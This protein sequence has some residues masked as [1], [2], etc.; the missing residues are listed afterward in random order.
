MWS[1][2]RPAQLATRASSRSSAARAA[3]R[4]RRLRGARVD[5]ELAPGLG[6]DQ[7]QVAHGGQLLLARVADLDR[8]HVVAAAAAGGAACA[9]RAGPRKSDT[10]TTRPRWPREL[11]PRALSAS[12]RRVAPAPS[13][14]GLGA[15]R[16]Q[17]A[18]QAA[19]ALARAQRD[20]AR[21][22]PNGQHAE[23]VALPRRDVPDRERRALGDVGLAA[24]GGAEAHRGRGVEQQPG[25]ER[26]L[27][28]VHAHVRLARARGD[29]PVDLAH[30]VAELVGP[31]LRELGAASRAPARGARPDT[32]LSIRRA[33]RQVERPQDGRRASDPVRAAPAC[34]R[35]AGAAS[36]A[37]SP[38]ARER[39]VR[40]LHGLDAPGRGARRRR[41]LR[42]RLVGQHEAV[43]QHVVRERA[44]RP[45]G[46]RSRARAGA[47]ARARR[48]S[49]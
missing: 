37:A 40:G 4:W 44:R 33:N 2:P 18:E 38:D 48:G 35:V 7:P 32:R 14:G 8:D 43:A 41:A 45:R 11:R 10:I 17:Q 29:A 19:A 13:G 24:V 49:G 42:E 23:P 39:D 16:E 28:D 12:P 1:A 20:A 6:V 9:S 27:R 15:Q 5:A 30:V 21:A 34:G 47:R 31:D 25:R 46:A 36:S 26:A 3:K 22:P